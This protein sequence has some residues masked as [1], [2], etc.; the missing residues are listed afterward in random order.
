MVRALRP[1]T[2]KTPKPFVWHEDRTYLILGGTGG[3]GF[4]TARHL[5]CNSRCRIALVG[6]RSL[7]DSIRERLTELER[8]GAQAIYLQA[9]ATD[10]TSMAAAVKSVHDRF[11]PIHGAF[12]SALVLDDRTIDRMDEAT[13][14]RVLSSKTTTTVTL[15]RSLREEP[16]DF[17]VCFS[18]AES[19]AGDAGQ[20]NY[21]AGCT[22]QDAYVQALRQNLRMP[23]KTINWG[24]WG[25]VGAVASD[26]YRIR[27]QEAGLMSI[28]PEE[29]MQALESL[30]SGDISQMLAAKC[31]DAVLARLGVTTTAT[32]GSAE[33]FLA[34][35]KA[36]EEDGKRQLLAT[37]RR[38]AAPFDL[39]H[40][41]SRDDLRN[42]LGVVPSQEKLF[43]ALLSLLT[44]AGLLQRQSNGWLLREAEVDANSLKEALP[45]H[46][47]LLRRCIEATPE[48]LRGEIPGTD[49][50]F[51]DGGMSLVSAIYQG[52]PITDACNR[53][54]AEK[55]RDIASQFLA[56][57]PFRIL[58][59]GA[60][61][62][63]TTAS[64]LPALAALGVSF[65]YV[66]SDVSPAFLRHGRK[67]FG[68]QYPQMTFQVLDIELNPQAQGFGGGS[69]D[70][71]LAANVLHATRDLKETLRR[72]KTLVDSFGHL[73]LNE[74]TEIDHFLTMTFGL[75]PGWWA[76]EDIHRR[77]M[78]SPLASRQSW[79]LV[80]E[81]SGWDIE[82]SGT[83]LS[84]R[85]FVASP[86][87]RLIRADAV[88]DAVRS[89]LAKTLDIPESRILPEVAFLDLGLDS[90]TAIEVVRRINALLNSSLRS[91]DLYNYSTVQ[92]LCERL[93]EL[94][95]AHTPAPVVTDS[96]VK[97]LE[98]VAMG[99][100]AV[101]D[102]AFA[103]LGTHG[104]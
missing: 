1:L 83:D 75:L 32:P 90:L 16:L 61:T 104:E 94:G 4:E 53:L 56:L 101:D 17:L 50:L 76:P 57:R 102:A 49:V 22:F 71:V 96:M 91:M 72:V 39:H 84:A 36:L 86:A 44:S 11:G 48:C 34:K 63:G 87:E 58:E 35:L 42:S 7:S 3:I 88:I 14:R 29:G 103:L 46:A 80:L 2:H 85:I 92:K 9:D 70:L 23:A 77:Y 31:T 54:V 67:L 27:L 64:V 82:R 8:A 78:H 60:G 41:V 69:F 68:T 100:L 30:L 18:S 33:S 5:A 62:G 51:G 13:F 66:Y 74:A 65:E 55:V 38:A 15:A 45:A 43:D 40:P 59:I 37:L 79:E 24:Y 93:A 73:L 89:A 98:R 97:L 95:A 47:K 26:A 81:E 99:D 20:S 19:F 25:T 12:H 28:A 6:R 52:D 21:S 10:E